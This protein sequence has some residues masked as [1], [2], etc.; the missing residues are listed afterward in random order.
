[1]ALVFLASSL[2]FSPGPACRLAVTPIPTRV[3][4][5]AGWGPDAG[6]WAMPTSSEELADVV[7]QPG[8][9]VVFFGSTRCRACQAERS[10][11]KSSAGRRPRLT[12]GRA[13]TSHCH[14]FHAAPFEHSGPAAGA[15]PEGRLPER[16]LRVREPEL[17]RHG[18]QTV[19]SR[20]AS[21]GPHLQRRRDGHTGRPFRW[22]DEA[23]TL[24]DDPSAT[25][26]PTPNPD[27]DRPTPR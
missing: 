19:Q 14:A 27:P 2:A 1:M 10:R 3:V 13:F 24:P 22:R 6:T 18:A 5:M 20:P 7:T 4:S 15:A 17:V 21:A 9:N 8:V 26:N 23:R 12:A 11:V 25:P 16:A